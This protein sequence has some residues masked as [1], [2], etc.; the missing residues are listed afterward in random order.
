MRFGSC[1]SSSTTDENASRLRPLGRRESKIGSIHPAYEFRHASLHDRFLCLHFGATSLPLV[2]SSERAEGRKWREE[3]MCSPVSES[4]YHHA[5]TN[6]YLPFAKLRPSTKAFPPIA[7][8]SKNNWVRDLF[9][10]L[11]YSGHSGCCGCEQ[12][13]QA[14]MGG[15]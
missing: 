15:D 7:Q 11:L 3:R 10:S 5:S 14:W 4:L 12:H 13:P 9:V 6:R 1:F 8:F 2:P